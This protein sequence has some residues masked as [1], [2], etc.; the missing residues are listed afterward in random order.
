[1]PSLLTSFLLK[2][3][4]FTA[5]ELDIIGTKFQEETIDENELFLRAGEI[6]NK[7]AL[8]ASGRFILAQS[9][10]LGN[11]RILDFFI[12]G[13]LIADYYSLLKKLPADSNIRALKKGH[14][15]VIHKKELESLLDTMPSFQI[16][17]RKLA[18]ESFVRLAE[19]IKSSS[20]SP[21]E[22]YQLLIDNKP[23][24]V[25]GF[26]QYMLASYLDMSPEWL[27]K[28]RNKK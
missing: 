15:Y 3:V 26:P 16:L 7:I 5:D 8:I 6:C 9:S 20:L 12:A 18:E 22:R 11:E 23:E 24:I 1:M 28:I 10:P 13:E 17:G 27:S 4:D 2:Y 19:S 25:Q 21:K 14:L